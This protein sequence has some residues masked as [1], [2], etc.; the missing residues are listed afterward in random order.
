MLPINPDWPTTNVWTKALEI[1]TNTNL[2]GKDAFFRTST[3]ILK[4]IPRD[5][6]QLFYILK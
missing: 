4:Q 5:T 1:I 6:L 3:Y 2:L